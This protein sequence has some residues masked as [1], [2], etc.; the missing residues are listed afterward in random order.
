MFSASGEIDR[1]NKIPEMDSKMSILVRDQA[2]CSCDVYPT[3]GAC[4]EAAP[5][6]S[7][8]T[9]SSSS[10][11]GNSGARGIRRKDTKGYEQSLFPHRR[12]FKRK[13]LCSDHSVGDFRVHSR[14]LFP[15]LSL[16]RNRASRTVQCWA[17]LE[18]SEKGT[19]P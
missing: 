8:E 18:F 17:N 14:V 12:I 9:T 19:N 7:L 6:R 11:Q 16:S 1:A 2:N 4:L 5:A 13:E 10:Y 15:R 3:E